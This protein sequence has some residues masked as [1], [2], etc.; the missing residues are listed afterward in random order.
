V[1]RKPGNVRRREDF[2]GPP[3]LARFFRGAR[4]ETMPARE[5]DR[6]AVLEHIVTR[7]ERGRAYEEREVNSLLSDV[8]ADFATLRRYLV[9]AGLLTRERNVYRRA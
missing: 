7:F 8:D 2:G 3:G 4:L 5:P 9:D 6:R 1:E